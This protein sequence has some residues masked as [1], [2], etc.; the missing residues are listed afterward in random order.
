M[1]VAL[2][3]HCRVH[4]REVVSLEVICVEYG[5]DKTEVIGDTSIMVTGLVVVMIII[6][7]TSAAGK[8]AEEDIDRLNEIGDCGLCQTVFVKDCMIIMKKMVTPVM[9]RRCVSRK[10]VGESCS[11]GV[12]N[13]CSIR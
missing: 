10:V 1:S 11:G 7:A 3:A 8:I 12:R 13:K 4:S 2:T 9:V 6:Y 5:D